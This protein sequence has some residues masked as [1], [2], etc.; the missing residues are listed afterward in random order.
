MKIARVDRRRQCT[1][2]GK[3]FILRL[4]ESAL[5]TETE[6]RNIQINLLTTKSNL[7]ENEKDASEHPYLDGREALG[8]G[9][10]GRD[11]VEDVDEHEEQ[12]DE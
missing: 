2:I 12:R 1:G 3:T 11:V 5:R 8:L 6:Q 7:T 9:R 10:V 4:R